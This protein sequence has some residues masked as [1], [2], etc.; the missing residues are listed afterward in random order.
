MQ[1]KFKNNGLFYL[2]PQL[3]ELEFHSSNNLLT[4]LSIE[5]N[6]DDFEEGESL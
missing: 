3:W 5:G 2:A 1:Q 4:T 6:I